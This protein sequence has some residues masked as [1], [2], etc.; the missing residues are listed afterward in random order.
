MGQVFF[1]WVPNPNLLWY[2]FNKSF[3]R[4]FQGGELKSTFDYLHEFSSKDIK[5]DMANVGSDCFNPFSFNFWKPWH[6]ET[7]IKNNR[8][9]VNFWKEP[10]C[11]DE[12]S[13]V[14][15][16][17][18]HLYQWGFFSKLFQL[19]RTDSFIFGPKVLTIWYQ[20]IFHLVG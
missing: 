12:D 18:V 10:M 2:P 13:P 19:D 15:E 11:P 14:E 20:W 9:K 8:I 16:N 6:M 5:I 3:W 7:K 17:M 1:C 4:E